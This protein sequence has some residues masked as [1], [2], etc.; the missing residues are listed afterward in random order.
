MRERGNLRETDR[1]KE[2]GMIDLRWKQLL[3][4]VGRQNTMGRIAHECKKIERRKTDRPDS[5][6]LSTFIRVFL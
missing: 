6:S 5:S 2:L 1:Y 4:R 3:G